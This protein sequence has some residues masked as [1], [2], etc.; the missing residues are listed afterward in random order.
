[1]TLIVGHP[2]VSPDCKGKCGSGSLICCS[3]LILFYPGLLGPCSFTEPDRAA[4]EPAFDCHRLMNGFFLA[5]SKTATGRKRSCA[6]FLTHLPLCNGHCPNDGGLWRGRAPRNPKPSLN[7]Q[8]PRNLVPYP[9][10]IPSVNEWLWDRCGFAD[11]L[12]LKEI[13]GTTCGSELHIGWVRAHGPNAYSKVVTR[14]M[15]EM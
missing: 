8:L 4:S 7:A 13:M 14:K 6:P 11:K 3:F 5:R 2:V 1:M 15:R 9:G 10:T 12:R